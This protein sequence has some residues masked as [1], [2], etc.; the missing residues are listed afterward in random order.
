MHSLKGWSKAKFG[1]V[2][3]ELEVLQN[4]LEELGANPHEAN[5]EEVNKIRQ[6]MDE[7]L[8]REKIMWLQ[9]SRISWLQEGDHNT[10]Y[11]HRKVAAR[12]RKNRV[13]RLRKDD[14]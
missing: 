5:H 2:T 1:A 6:H 14:G 11:F 12:A 4:R 7:V 10:K 13:K 9:R 3:R 8:Y